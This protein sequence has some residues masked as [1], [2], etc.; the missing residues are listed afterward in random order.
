MSSDLCPAFSGFPNDLLS[1]KGHILHTYSTSA[2]AAVSLIF[3]GVPLFSQCNLR[4][5]GS[6]CC[7]LD[8]RLLNKN[9]CPLI[10]HRVAHLPQNKPEY[11]NRRHSGGGKCSQCRHAFPIHGDTGAININR[12]ISVMSSVFTGF[13]LRGLLRQPFLGEQ[14]L[15]C[16]FPAV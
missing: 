3:T 12:R 5:I 9:A 13:P 11:R 10:A 16:L 15:F 14:L 2:R 8:H 7:R 1:Q 6:S 4:S